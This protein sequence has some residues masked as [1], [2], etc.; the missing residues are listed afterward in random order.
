MK[1]LILATFLLSFAV[2]ASGQADAKYLVNLNG[3]GLG[4]DYSDVI[5]EF[6]KPKTE[7]T[8]D[9]DECR[10]SKIRT[11]VYDGLKLELSEPSQP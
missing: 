2:A 5:K 9:G 10:G 7:T 1:S 11:M 8:L 3:I 4:S 6:G